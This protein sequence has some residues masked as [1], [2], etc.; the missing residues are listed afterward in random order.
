MINPPASIVPSAK[1]NKSKQVF[2]GS[3]YSLHGLPLMQDKKYLYAKNLISFAI[4]ML[5]AVVL[6]VWSQ[7]LKFVCLL[8]H[9]LSCMFELCQSGGEICAP[10]AALT[11][12]QSSKQPALP[13]RYTS[14]AL[15]LSC[16]EKQN[17]YTFFG[18]FMLLQTWV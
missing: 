8:Q 13:I 10:L 14:N 16:D 3:H 4:I 1:Q 6:L 18:L 11:H 15:G 9:L 17:K 2:V 12:A 7:F 5:P